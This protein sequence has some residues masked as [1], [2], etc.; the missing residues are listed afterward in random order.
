MKWELRNGD[1]ETGT[2]EWGL[3]NGDQEVEIF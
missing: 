1:L 2:K 3:R